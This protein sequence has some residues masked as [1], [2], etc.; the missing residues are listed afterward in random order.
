MHSSCLTSHACE[1]VVSD[2]GKKSCQCCCEK[3]RTHR[4]VTYGH[5]MTIVVK[6]ALNPNT[7]EQIILSSPL[8]KK[9]IIY[10]KICIIYIG[11]VMS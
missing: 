3:A 5:D 1:K 9:K 11:S 8:E 10:L 2:F 4:C 6:M 7:N